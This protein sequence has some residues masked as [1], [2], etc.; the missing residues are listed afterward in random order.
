MVVTRKRS[1]FSREEWGFVPTRHA[2]DGERAPFTLV[3]VVGNLALRTRLPSST[4]K[5]AESNSEAV[6]PQTVAWLDGSLVKNTSSFHEK[7]HPSVQHLGQRFAGMA[8]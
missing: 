6:F 8:T 5:E 3:G 1:G 4:L 7:R 2:A